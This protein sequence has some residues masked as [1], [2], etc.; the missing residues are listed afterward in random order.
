MDATSGL[1]H[2]H[3]RRPDPRAPDS[4]QVWR[5]WTEMTTPDNGVVVTQEGHIGGRVI[6]VEI[7]LDTMAGLHPSEWLT[8]EVT[9]RQQA[10]WTVTMSS[11]EQRIPGQT[12]ERLYSIVA[13]KDNQYR[14]ATQIT[15]FV[16]SLTDQADIDWVT[17]ETLRI[18]EKDDRPPE[19]EAEVQLGRDLVRIMVAKRGKVLVASVPEGSIA[20]MVLAVWTSTSLFAATIT[21]TDE[22]GKKVERDQLISELALPDWLEEIARSCGLRASLPRPGRWVQSN[23]HLQPIVF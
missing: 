15:R 7:G 11:H 14:V 4:I 19:W 1:Q 8:R 23:T 20:D 13:E 17:P 3:L 18:L 21:I 6:Q 22:Q 16:D 2:V 9:A 12:P 5:A 10:G